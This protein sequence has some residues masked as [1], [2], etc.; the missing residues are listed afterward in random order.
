MTQR[1]I[2]QVDVISSVV[3]TQELLA[4]LARDKVFM[5]QHGHLRLSYGTGRDSKDH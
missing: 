5:R 2:P 4:H 1:E 3:E